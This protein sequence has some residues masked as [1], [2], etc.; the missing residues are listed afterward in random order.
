MSASLDAMMEQTFLSRLMRRLRYRKLLITC[1][2]ILLFTISG[3][4]IAVLPRS[5]EGIASVA[6]EGQTPTAV[7]NGDVLRDMPFDDQTIGTELAILESRELFADTI[8]QVGLLS[9]AE[10]NAALRRPGLVGQ[11]LMILRAKLN[12]LDT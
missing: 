5:Y 4:A 7:Q 11:V 9:N 10:F 1:L 3:L 8:N 12:S 6:I 2:T